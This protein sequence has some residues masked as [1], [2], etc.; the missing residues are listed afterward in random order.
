MIDDDFTNQTFTLNVGDGHKLYV[1]DWG[2]KKAETPFIFLHGGPGGQ[3]EDRH[4]SSFDPESHRVIFFDQRGCGQ[5]TPYGS[6]KS[7]TTKDLADDITNI[8]EHL[9]IPKFNLYGYSWGATL[10]LYYAIQYPEK[11]KNLVIGGVYGGD[12]DLPQ[13]FDRLQNFFP[14]IYAKLFP[15]APKNHALAHQLQSEILSGTPSQKKRA[16]FTLGAIESTLANYDSNLAARP[17]YAD[18]DSVPAQIETHYIAND[19]FMPKGY[20]I[21][22]AHKITAQVYIVQGRADLICPPEFAYQI[23]QKI[24]RAKLFW[25]VSN[26]RKEREPNSVFRAICATLD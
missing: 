10:A 14:D 17:D 20:L 19:C 8:A 5:S 4:K 22:N 21:K 15:D 24:P 12:N 23:S 7:N 16:C 3:V 6:L 18:Y 1:V 9:N 2:N 26:H 11:V 13:Q 25:T